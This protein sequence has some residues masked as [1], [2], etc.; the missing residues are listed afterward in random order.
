MCC[1]SVFFRF[2]QDIIINDKWKIKSDEVGNLLAH[3][4][5]LHPGA[6]MEFVMEEFERDP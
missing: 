1:I 4:E 3:I 2:L 5:L 6:A